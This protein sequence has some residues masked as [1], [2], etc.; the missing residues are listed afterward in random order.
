MTFWDRAATLQI[1]PKLY[2]LSKLYFTFDIPFVDSEELNTG[3]ITAHNLSKATRSEIKKGMVVI[4]NA[5][6]VGD[7][8]CIFVGKVSRCVSKQQGTE[9][10]TTITA[11]TALDEWLTSEVNKTYAAGSK[12]SSI[13]KD[14]LNIFGVEIGTFELVVDKD[15]PRGKVCKGKVKD[16]VRE[17]ATLD[18]KSRFLIRNGTVIINDPTKGQNMGYLLSSATGLLKATDE[19]EDTEPV[20]NQT[21]IDDGGEAEEQTYTRRCLLNYHL[22][23]ADVVTIQERILNGAFL[24]KAGRHTGNPT[25]DW[26][27]EIEVKPV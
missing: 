18:C 14:L 13:L 11:A 22:A 1:G 23:A 17:I 26:V 25:G 10:I 9:W 20:T 2:D 5:G 3:T 15:Y 4:I 21:T 16:V 8:G 7:L 27:T 6:Y 19:M 12:A 24:V